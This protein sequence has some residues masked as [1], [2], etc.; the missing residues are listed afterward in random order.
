MPSLSPELCNLLDVQIQIERW[1]KTIEKLSRRLKNLR[2]LVVLD[3]ALSL[4]VVTD[5]NCGF[6]VSWQAY[7]FCTDRNIWLCRM[8]CGQLCS[9]HRQFSKGLM[10]GLWLF[11]M[12]GGAWLPVPKWAGIYGGHTRPR[13]LVATSGLR[14]L[15]HLI[16][17]TSVNCSV[18]QSYPKTGGRVYRTTLTLGVGWDPLWVWPDYPHLLEWSLNGHSLCP[19][20]TQRPFAI[21][22]HWMTTALRRQTTKMS[23]LFE[24]EKPIASAWFPLLAAI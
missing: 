18:T 2:N 15:S 17:Y 20:G 11:G 9:R 5:W 1:L 24:L 12:A 23:S 22:W 19:M 7:L 13:C 14:L 16:Q 8:S 10:S 6:V 21:T 4:E 3:M